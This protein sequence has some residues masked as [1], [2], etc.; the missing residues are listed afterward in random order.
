MC[1]ADADDV[2][3]VK[4]VAYVCCFM[5]AATAAAAAVAIEASIVCRSVIIKIKW[6]LW[7]R[8]CF[9][10]VCSQSRIHLVSLRYARANVIFRRWQLPRVMRCSYVGCRVLRILLFWFFFSSASPQTCRKSV[11]NESPEK[12]RP[13]ILFACCG[14]AFHFNMTRQKRLWTF[15]HQQKAWFFFQARIAFI[16]PNLDEKWMAP[17][18]SNHTNVERSV[19]GWWWWWLAWRSRAKSK[20][21]LCGG[22]KSDLVFFVKLS[23]SLRHRIY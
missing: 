9:D 11:I 3:T 18:N 10:V 16:V 21:K 8:W 14:S 15:R 12:A 22:A 2:M 19:F 17:E 4:V 6:N 7:S 5:P 1:W 23:T 13:K 20:Y